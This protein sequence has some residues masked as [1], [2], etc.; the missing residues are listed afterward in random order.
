M[1]I[2]EYLC[3]NCEKRFEA[4]RPIGQADAPLACA[5]CGGENV[6]RKQSVFYA[7]SGGHSVAGTSGGCNCDSA[8]PGGNCAGCS[9]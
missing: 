8:C 7:R 2:Y 4:I 3:L 5:A 6:K 1:P 9:H